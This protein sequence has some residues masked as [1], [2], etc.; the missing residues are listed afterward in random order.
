MKVLLTK[1]FMTEDLDYI[2]SRIH[3]SIELIE[4]EFYNEDSILSV[5]ADIDVFLGNY[6]TDKVLSRAKKLKFIQIPWTGVDNLDFEILLKHKTQVCNSHSNALTVAEHSIALM[7]DAAKKISFH[8]RLMRVGKWNRVNPERTNTISP[9]S[10]RI[11][12]SI[13]GIIGFGAIGKSIYN[14]LKGYNCSFKVFTQDKSSVLESDTS[15]DIFSPEAIYTELHEVDFIFV[16]VPLTSQTRHLINKNLLDSVNSSTIL[17]N[18]S[19]GEVMNEEDLYNALSDKSIAFAA[20]DTWFNYPTRDNPDVFPSNNFDFH[21]L[22]NIVLSPHRAGYEEGGFPHLDD[23]IENINRYFAG[24]PL[25][26]IVSL[27]AGY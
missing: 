22:D 2:K 26:N 18:I 12:N 11:S 21:L 5:V 20:I 24:K 1:S 8:D 14:L 19:R 3:S 7:M 10:S 4:P 6:Y 13:V 15:L 9:F 23:A 25:I 27:N 16:S 17:I